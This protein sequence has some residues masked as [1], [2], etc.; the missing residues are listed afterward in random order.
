M[1]RHMVH[2]VITAGGIRDCTGF[3]LFLSV[4]ELTVMTFWL[5]TLIRH[6]YGDMMIV[7]TPSVVVCQRGNQTCLVHS[8][9][10]LPPD[11]GETS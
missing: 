10:F 7:Q 9:N 1:G 4:S 3:H 6:Q 5:Q 11:V 2:D 8:Y